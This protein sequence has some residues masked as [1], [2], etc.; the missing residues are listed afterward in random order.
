MKKRLLRKPATRLRV[1]KYEAS[2]TLAGRSYERGGGNRAVSRNYY[3]KFSKQY[4]RGAV[5]STHIIL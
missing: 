1:W 3:P 5:F 2:A 4:S